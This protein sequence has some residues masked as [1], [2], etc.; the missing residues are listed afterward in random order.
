TQNVISFLERG[1]YMNKKVVRVLALILV[2]LLLLPFV[3]GICR[4]ITTG[5]YQF[6]DVT[7]KPNRV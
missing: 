3:Y 7:V 1:E 2:A 4:T 6:I 5:G